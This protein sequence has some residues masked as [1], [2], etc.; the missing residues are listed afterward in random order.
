MQINVGHSQKQQ[1][2]FDNL[3]LYNWKLVTFFLPKK[4]CW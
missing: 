4:E 3:K 2:F 1:N